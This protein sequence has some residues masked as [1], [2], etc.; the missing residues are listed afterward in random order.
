MDNN[1]ENEKQRKINLEIR[2][3]IALIGL[4]AFGGAFVTFIIKRFL[5]LIVN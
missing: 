1:E 4:L 5:D 2:L 3:R